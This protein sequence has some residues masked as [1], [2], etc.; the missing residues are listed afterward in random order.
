MAVIIFLK[1]FR[2]GISVWN[3]S[4]KLALAALILYAVNAVCRSKPSFISNAL[5]YIRKA[6]SDLMILFVIGFC[7]IAAFIFDAI[8]VSDVYGAFVFGLLIGNVYKHRHSMLSLC[9]P[10][11]AVLMSVFF[12]YIGLLINLDNIQK[13]LGIIILINTV[14]MVF[15]YL[16]N[17]S[18]N[19]IIHR[20]N[21]EFTTLCIII[22]SLLLTQMS[23]FSLLII[24]MV[25]YNVEAS[26]Q[27]IIFGMNR[28]DFYSFLEFLKSSSI[29][30]LTFGCLVTVLLKRIVYRRHSGKINELDGCK[31]TKN[32]EKPDNNIGIQNVPVQYTKE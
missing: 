12:V 15:K 23:E 27:S 8:G 22:S 31:M 5:D 7:C 11:S 32:D 9:D 16:S 28:P 13:H 26:T 14:V 6:G 29:V 19:S 17:Y 20:D 25:M 3:L 24:E 1:G 30:S 21:P 4:Y 18:I 10:I 2:S